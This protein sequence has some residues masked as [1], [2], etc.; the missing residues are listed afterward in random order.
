MTI[1]NEPEMAE[2]RELTDVADKREWIKSLRVTRHDLLSKFKKQ[3]HEIS[4]ITSELIELSKAEYASYAI[5]RNDPEN[6]GLRVKFNEL[7][8]QHA[9]FF[10]KEVDMANAA[11][12]T[13]RSVNELSTLIDQ[14]ESVISG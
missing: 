11:H 7:V 13:I 8:A 9:P 10:R 2:F 6:D 14:M 12:E 4:L 1:Q 5:A 3:R